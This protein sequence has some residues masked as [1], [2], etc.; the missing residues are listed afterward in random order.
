MSTPTT[1]ATAASMGGDGQLQSNDIVFQTIHSK[2]TQ[3]VQ[4][5]SL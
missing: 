3:C 1:P 5:N 2:R 4:M